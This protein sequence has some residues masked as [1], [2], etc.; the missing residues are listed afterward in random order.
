MPSIQTAIDLEQHCKANGIE[1]T[2]VG[3]PKDPTDAVKSLARQ[4]ARIIVGMFYGGPARKVMCEAYKQKLYGKQHV[5]FLIGWY[6]DNWYEPGAENLT[7]TREEMLKVVDGHFTT[8]AIILNRDKKQTISGITAQE[9]QKA[10]DKK[11][12]E[13]YNTSK[14]LGK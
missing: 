9:W 7:C 10:Y 13:L 3:F 8:E 4:D 12:I 6:E 2:R 11:V 1:S 14:P 5:W